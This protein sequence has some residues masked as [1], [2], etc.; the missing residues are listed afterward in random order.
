MM[1]LPLPIT[2]AAL[3]GFIT[4]AI[5]TSAY[6]INK[7]DKM[8][9][10]HLDYFILIGYVSF[11]LL[12]LPLIKKLHKYVV[13]DFKSQNKGEEIDYI[14]ERANRLLHEVC[15]EEHTPHAIKRAHAAYKG[16]KHII[17]ASDMTPQRELVLKLSALLYVVNGPQFQPE[18]Y[19][20]S[21]ILNQILHKYKYEEAVSNA[22][23][24][25]INNIHNGNGCDNA[26]YIVVS[27]VIQCVDYDN[28]DS[29]S[30]SDYA[31]SD[32]DDRTIVVDVSALML[33]S[34][35]VATLNNATFNGTTFNDTT[36]DNTTFNDKKTV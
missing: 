15:A 28:S 13:R 8:S 11:I 32:S 4:S 19:L 16:I 1:L 30:S 34:H 25:I 20:A 2:C 33:S 29:D 35:D 21:Q 22:V 36:L 31:S 18:D 23:M 7:Y 5:Y 10:K 9:A 6:L 14:V 12:M 26:D 27:H 24:L 3:S 17:R